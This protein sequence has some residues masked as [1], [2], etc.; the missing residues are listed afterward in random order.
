MASAYAQLLGF[1]N[2]GEIH[3]GLKLTSSQTDNIDAEGRTWVPFRT[4]N[5]KNLNERL[6]ANATYRGYSHIAVYSTKDTP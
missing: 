5:S 6:G 1:T 3:E 4:R 2:G